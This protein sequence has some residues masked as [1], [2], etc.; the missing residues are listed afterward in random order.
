M[1]LSTQPLG[2]LNVRA[3]ELTVGP[4]GEKA[5]PGE[6]PPSSAYTYAVDPWWGRGH[7]PG[8]PLMPGVLMLEAAAHLGE[9][10]GGLDDPAV[11]GERGQMEGRL[12]R[13]G[14]PERARSEYGRIEKAGASRDRAAIP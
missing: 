7:I 1:L 5:M 3:T 9:F 11:A 14:T 4:N 12:T 13:Q 2:D 6:L 8:R 10:A